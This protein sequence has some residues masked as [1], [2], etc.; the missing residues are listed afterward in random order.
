MGSEH[1]SRQTWACWGM[2]L[3]FVLTLMSRGVTF[4]T[5]L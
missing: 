5:G 4:L 2:T 1:T 3:L